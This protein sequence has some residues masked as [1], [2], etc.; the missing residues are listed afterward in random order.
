MIKKRQLA[1]FLT[2]ALI[3]IALFFIVPLIYLIVVSFYNW[4]GIGPMEWNGWG[5]YYQ[6]LVK[7]KIFRTALINTITWII[8]ACVIHIPLAIILALLLNRKPCGWKKLRVLYFI[9][10]V[11]STTAIA[12]LWYFIFH[13]DVGLLNNVL[14]KIGLDSL[15]HNWLGEIN[16][17]KFSVQVPFALYVGLSMVI[18]LTQL[19]LI[20]PDLYEVAKVDGA[21]QAQIDRY[22]CLP[23]LKPAIITNLLLNIS[24]CLKN[25]EYPSLM[26]NGGPANSTMNLSLYIYWEMMSVNKYGISMVASLVTV[27]LGLI[28]MLVIRKAERAGE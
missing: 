3:I 2:P 9:P 15:A 6:T 16:T 14:K 27:I 25:F 13:V 8:T 10:N 26:T 18:F 22:I 21:S 5:N 1:V 28:V 24:F 20:S 23:L 7:D 12:F 11:I 17:A 19:S 4:N